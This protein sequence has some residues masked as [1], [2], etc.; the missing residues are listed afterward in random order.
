MEFREWLIKRKIYS[1]RSIQDILSRVKRVKK[2]LNIEEIDRETE[3][4][5]NSSEKFLKL[6]C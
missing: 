2:I 6:S 5:L 3:E 4:K 1:E